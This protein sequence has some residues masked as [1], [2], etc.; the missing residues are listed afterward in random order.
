M[1]FECC[2]S[3]CAQGNLSLWKLCFPL[4]KLIKN[5][6]PESVSSKSVP[7]SYTQIFASAWIHTYKQAP[8]IQL[9]TD[10]GKMILIGTCKE[11]Y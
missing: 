4:A 8:I 1:N 3:R 9:T 6:S 10:N 11:N 7:Q 5:I 2:Y